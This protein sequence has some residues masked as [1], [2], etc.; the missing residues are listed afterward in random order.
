M[1][2]HEVPVLIVGAGPVGLSAA[3]ALSRF[4]VECLLVEK[5]PGTSTHPKARGINVRTMEIMRNWYLENAIRRHE[6]PRE[7]LRFM[8]AS[9]LEDQTPISVERH[10][11][12]LDFSPTTGSFVSQDWVEKE[13]LNDLNQYPK[14]QVALSTELTDL[15]F[16]NDGVVA[17]LKNRTTDSIQQIFAHY[18]IA[19]DGAHSMIRNAISANMIGVENLG[20]FCS[21]YCEV[22]LTQKIQGKQC[23]VMVFTK[24]ELRH[25]VLMSV[26]GAHKWIFAIRYS[27]EEGYSK[28][29]FTREKCIEIVKSIIDDENIDVKLINRNFWNMAALNADTYATKRIFLTGD[30][31]HRLPPTGGFG[32]N[33]GI[34]DAHNLAWKLAYLIKGYANE[35]I[36]ESYQL[37]RQ[38]IAKA[39]IDWSA[40]NA[41]RIVK[42]FMALEAGDTALAETLIQSQEQHLN[43]LGLDIGFIYREGL[44]IHDDSRYEI[45]LVDYK[46]SGTPG[47]RAPHVELKFGDKLLSTLD[48][49]DKHFVVLSSNKDWVSIVDSLN[50]NIV[51]TIKVII[52]GRSGYYEDIHQDFKVRYGLSNEG[53]VIVRPDGHIAWRTQVID[54]KAFEAAISE[55][56]LLK[57]S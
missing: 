54:K 25:A 13:L 31:A 17:T 11:D 26:D 29:Y 52:I 18:L 20:N 21:I 48:F 6:L 41:D 14:C 39:N 49:F 35:G 10:E 47:V 33:T 45:D 42:I 40:S 24:P 46:P 53:A 16:N 32:M 56:K 36:L 12:N 28:D 19:A 22:D 1:A 4:D 43:N 57:K 3:I 51:G 2:D 9:D 7:A 30:A 8:W 27:E 38:P 5:H 23:A 15:E 55:L 34:Q 50:G 44:L 37:E